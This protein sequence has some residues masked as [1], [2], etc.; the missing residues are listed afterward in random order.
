ML[1]VLSTNRLSA[2]LL[3]THIVLNIT[4]T[5]DTI[6]ADKVHD[7]KTKQKQMNSS[8]STNIMKQN[9]NAQRTTVTRHQVPI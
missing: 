4:E 3:N 7:N 9:Q 1:M 8:R 2:N 5:E 6:V